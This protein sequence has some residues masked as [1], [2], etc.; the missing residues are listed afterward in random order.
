MG[1]NQFVLQRIISWIPRTHMRAPVIDGVNLSFVEKE[2]DGV[3]VRLDDLRVIFPEVVR[4]GDPDERLFG[5]HVSSFGTW[6]QNPSLK[7]IYVTPVSVGG[8]F[9]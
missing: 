8:T 9:L 1:F 3:A 2:S 6:H 4:V 7:R 5:C